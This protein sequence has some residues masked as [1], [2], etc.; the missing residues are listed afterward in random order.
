L[1]EKAGML[2]HRSHN[3][4]PT[5]QPVTVATLTSFPAHDLDAGKGWA[6][7]ASPAEQFGW[8]IRSVP[9]PFATAP[10]FHSILAAR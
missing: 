9:L 3:P 4:P 1:W 5:L 7:R 10:L 2:L 8:A 6:H